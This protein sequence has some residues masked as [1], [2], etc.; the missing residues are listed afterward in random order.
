MKLPRT[1]TRGSSAPPPTLALTTASI[2]L[3]YATTTPNLRPRRRARSPRANPGGQRLGSPF[4]FHPGVRAT[5]PSIAEEVRACQPRSTYWLRSSTYTDLTW[6][7]TPM[8]LERLITHARRTSDTPLLARCQQV[9]VESVMMYINGP[10][11]RESLSCMELERLIQYAG[12]FGFWELDRLPG[13]AGEPVDRY[14]TPP[15]QIL[16]SHY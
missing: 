13:R 5:S 9:L 2:R 14:A 4:T 16:H 7:T 10:E 15:A 3:S 8:D 11:T 1:T 12:L 6:L